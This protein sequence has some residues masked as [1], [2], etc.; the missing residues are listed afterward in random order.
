MP[1]FYSEINEVKPCGKKNLPVIVKKA[2]KHIFF[3]V[4]FANEPIHDL[5]LRFV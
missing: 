1:S 2:A 3:H 4:L 5:D